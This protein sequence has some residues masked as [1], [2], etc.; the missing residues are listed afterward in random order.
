MTTTDPK[1]KRKNTSREPIPYFRQRAWLT[2]ITF[3]LFVEWGKLRGIL[4]VTS[5][6]CLVYIFPLTVWLFVVSGIVL[7]LVAALPDVGVGF[8]VQRIVPPPEV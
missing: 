5:T 2:G 8:L 4:V 1:P 3:V 6:G 7:P